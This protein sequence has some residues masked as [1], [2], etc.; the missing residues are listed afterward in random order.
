MSNQ[1]KT[2]MRVRLADGGPGQGVYGTV[3]ND[4]GFK[5]VRWD[6]AIITVPDGYTSMHH[7]DALMQWRINELR[8]GILR[9]G[10]NKL[11]S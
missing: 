4:E 8:T 10:N 1:I 6:A 5:T 2:D 7:P 11:L 3:I 9:S